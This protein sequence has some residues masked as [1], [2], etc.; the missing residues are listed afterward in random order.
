[1][2]SIIA[3]KAPQNSVLKLYK[4]R[5]LRNLMIKTVSVLTAFFYIF[6]FVLSPAVHAISETYNPTVAPK[7][8]QTS[9][10]SIPLTFGRITGTNYFGSDKVV[11]NIQD[12]HCNPEVQKNIS[13][14]IKF[15]DERFK[16]G[17][18]YLEGASGQ[19]DTSWLNNLSDEKTKRQIAD[20]LIEDG[21]LTGAEYYSIMS[22]QPLL[23]KG[24]ENK[25]LHKENII[26]LSRI[27]GR[28]NFFKD[29][30]DGLRREL[31]RMETVY[32]NGENRRFNKILEQYREKKLSTEKY[33]SL[34]NIIVS[35]INSSRNKYN[36][37]FVINRNNYPNFNS[38]LELSKLA[39]RF[40]Y[41]A[42]SHQLANAIS[43]LKSRIP[44]AEYELLIKKT[45]GFSRL[46]A[47]Y[48]ELKDYSAK[49]GLNRKYS[50]L[51]QFL[52]YVEKSKETNPL[53]MIKEERRLIEQIRSGLSKDIAELEVSFIADSFGYFE[54]Y[55]DNKLSSEDYAYFSA[56]FPK[57]RNYWGK[58]AVADKLEELFPDFRLLDEYYRV[59]DERSKIFIEN[60][61]GK[62]SYKGEA[63]AE[64]SHAKK[65]GKTLDWLKN[66]KDIIIVVAGGFHTE[67]FCR[68]LEE[69]KISYVTLTPN[70]AANPSRTD[71][72][73]ME[74]V[75]EQAQ[76]FARNALATLPPSASASIEQQRT[77]GTI[78]L[79]LYNNEVPFVKE[80]GKYTIKLPTINPSERMEY[81]HSNA[82]DII[83]YAAERFLTAINILSEIPCPNIYELVKIL[84]STLAE[85]NIFESDGLIFEIAQN[86][87]IQKAIKD[88]EIEKL[89][90]M[91]EI[92]QAAV[93]QKAKDEAIFNEFK[94]PQPE[95]V[96]PLL[97]MPLLRRFIFNLCDIREKELMGQRAEQNARKIESDQFKFE[98]GNTFLNLSESENT[99][100]LVRVHTAL[101]GVGEI[102]EIAQN[103]NFSEEV[104]TRLFSGEYL[105]VDIILENYSQNTVKYTP[106]YYYFYCPTKRRPNL[107]QQM[108]MKETTEVVNQRNA[109]SVNPKKASHAQKPDKDNLFL[110]DFVWN[111]TYDLIVNHPDTKNGQK[112]IRTAM[113]IA[114]AQNID[115]YPPDSP[116]SEKREW[117]LVKLAVVYSLLNQAPYHSKESEQLYRMA[118]LEDNS[119]VMKDF[120]EKHYG[121][122][123]ILF[124]FISIEKAKEHFYKALNDF[125]G[126]F[127]ESLGIKRERKPVSEEGIQIS[128]NHFHK[129]S[130]YNWLRSNNERINN[131]VKNGINPF[132]NIG[133]IVFMEA[134]PPD[135]E[136]IK[137]HLAEHFPKVLIL[138]WDGTIAY[139]ATTTSN[140]MTEILEKYLMAGTH[141]IVVSLNPGRFGGDLMERFKG[142]I[143]F[144]RYRNN[145][146]D[147]AKV[148]LQALKD[149]GISIEDAEILVAGDQPADVPMLK[150]FGS[151]SLSFYL[152]IS[153]Q[154]EFKLFNSNDKAF[155]LGRPIGL[156]NIRYEGPEG[157]LQILKLG[158]AEKE[159][160]KDVQT[161]PDRKLADVNTVS[162]IDSII[163]ETGKTTRRMDLIEI[164]GRKP[165]VLSLVVTISGL[166]LLNG[167][168]IMAITSILTL[169]HVAHILLQL[170]QILMVGI[171][172]PFL[173]V[174]GA[175]HSL[176]DSIVWPGTDR[177]TAI[178]KAAALTEPEILK[179]WKKRDFIGNNHINYTNLNK[180]QISGQLELLSKAYNSVHLGGILVAFLAG[181]VAFG[182]LSLG[183]LPIIMT[184]KIIIAISVGILY[185]IPGVLFSHYLNDKHSETKLANQS[186]YK[187][188][189]GYTLTSSLL[190]SLRNSVLK[191]FGKR[192]ISRGAPA[193]AFVCGRDKLFLALEKAKK[194][195]DKSTDKNITAFIITEMTELA[196]S[197]GILM[198]TIP[199]NVC[200][201]TPASP[202]TE[203]LKV[204]A[205]VR[206][207]TLIFYVN[208]EKLADVNAGEKN[209]I[210]SVC[211][212]Q[213]INQLR[214]EGNLEGDKNMLQ[215][216]KEIYPA[217]LKGSGG[218]N[219]ESGI[220]VDFTGT[221]G[222]D[223]YESIFP[224]SI[225]IGSPELDEANHL[226]L[227]RM[228]KTLD[229]ENISNSRSLGFLNTIVETDAS[230]TKQFLEAIDNFNSVGGS[231][232]INWEILA[233]LKNNEKRK[234]LITEAAKKVQVYVK[235][236]S[237]SGE[238][239]KE[240]IDFINDSGISGIFIDANESFISNLDNCLKF[241]TLKKDIII[242]SANNYGRNSIRP[243]RSIDLNKAID[244]SRFSGNE[245]IRVK[246][247]NN[248]NI[249]KL[250]S[251]KILPSTC[252][253]V[254][255]LDEIV[256]SIENNKD[257]T[258]MVKL[259]TS[260]NIF[261]VVPNE[262]RFV[263]SL[264]RSD[265]PNDEKIKDSVINALENS[266]FDEQEVN[267]L[268]E[269]MNGIYSSPI[270][271]HLQRIAREPKRVK[272]FLE[273]LA[274]QM[275]FN[276][277]IPENE[278]FINSENE[279]IFRK[280]I[281]DYELMNIGSQQKKETIA[282]ARAAAEDLRR[283]LENGVLTYEAFSNILN[284]KVRKLSAEAS[285]PE[286][287]GALIELLLIAER[288]P[289]IEIRDEDRGINTRNISSILEAA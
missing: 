136:A 219:I 11:I 108:V 220:V 141:I 221:P 248:F 70:I 152:G 265:L 72:V 235:Y 199:M 228:F 149:S 274:A 257:I 142:Q 155:G 104:R 262:T 65:M 115:F 260:L 218:R 14:L 114:R 81:I 9:D 150:A 18:V 189:I 273:A 278:E 38:F 166:L 133:G 74:I 85:N 125:L 50:Q 83:R 97:D 157:L 186:P 227:Q 259:V 93:M 16:V 271:W 64:V 82:A 145:K 119:E 148:A 78:V 120:A 188:T 223:G 289:V 147:S 287:V 282:K 182:M 76:M 86:P 46:D 244:Y 40:D 92:I 281:L 122:L 251:L 283:Q 111:R 113:N 159:E 185:Y 100:G 162:L 275:L 41:V 253:F 80:N 184:L 224:N 211:A 279:K 192:R 209:R 99:D 210:L 231:L 101:N 143:H 134:E 161:A 241:G 215:T 280:A 75:R 84:G 121:L 163:D 151:E 96:K 232:L 195:N 24:L 17:K 102:V 21:R 105:R 254:F 30:L 272:S 32:L 118:T 36:N 217:I 154:S 285:S 23:I 261:K 276:E 269:S 55:V 270:S 42:I 128:V 264:E 1:M 62:F 107:I 198:R 54:D 194:A 216:I 140:E 90:L 158:L 27:M 245:I 173:I 10:F 8:Q 207:D 19:V 112:A 47:I 239:D 171:G 37:L 57:F 205:G 127:N 249:S 132:F 201:N 7:V 187:K 117:G 66:S 28:K 3:P 4:H 123:E 213:I 200:V 5:V 124:P 164:Y 180:A 237:Y 203:F 204:Y 79:K 94:D 190:E 39:K 176:A 98:A 51:W 146:G 71:E 242:A 130:N 43:E 33:Y 258:E 129:N 236:K 246:I 175:Y 61:L 183:F 116:D 193:A 13:Q 178:A 52:D 181:L 68:L 225:I 106:S 103:T 284:Q 196:T 67:P 168:A 139:G 263:S 156:D 197:E 63:K 48:S 226:G 153:S 243:V 109:V 174:M 255:N 77:D 165:F 240:L 208:M 89:S 229:S 35:K 56:R 138:D 131:N 202:T 15:V 91:P 266:S 234:I 137:Q 135:L 167:L 277:R 20:A 160:R 250:H 144:A 230:N 31:R 29:K 53:A 45:D 25:Q 191:L 206:D 110:S 2:N 12:L 268:I 169:L 267:G 126:N 214:G 172:A 212:S 73:Y 44:Y 88:V 179:F 59:N 60:S 222:N 233:K 286:S 95:W 69:R 238:P 247:D 22:N 177:D 26:R 256:E 87:E 58:Y 252:I 170:I 288:R 6:S 49:Y 34:L